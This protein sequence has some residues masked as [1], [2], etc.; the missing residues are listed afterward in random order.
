METAPSTPSKIGPWYSKPPLAAA[1]LSFVIAIV[2]VGCD[3]AAVDNPPAKPE[4]QPMAEKT[5]PAGTVSA[6]LSARTDATLH[7]NDDGSF[8]LVSV[9]RGSTAV[10][11]VGGR[12]AI[13]ASPLV[14]RV[15]LTGTSAVDGTT[16]TLKITGAVRDDEELT[17]TDLTRYTACRITATI[18]SGFH[19]QAIGAMA[20]CLVDAGD[21]PVADQVAVKDNGLSQRLVGKWRFTSLKILPHPGIGKIDYSCEEV[22]FLGESLD[23][24]LE[25]PLLEFSPDT[26]G[27]TQY[28]PLFGLD[29]PDDVA[30]PEFLGVME[31][32]ISFSLGGVKTAIT[33]LTIQGGG[34][35]QSLH[36]DDARECSPIHEYAD[37]VLS[38]TELIDE[39]LPIP[40][41]I[42][43]D[44]Q[45]L[46]IGSGSIGIFLPIL[47]S[48]VE[49]TFEGEALEVRGEVRGYFFYQREP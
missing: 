23:I 16:A 22:R 5:V 35:T 31:L 33:H 30:P 29:D 44:D 45:T 9:T 39:D 8:E 42:S 17:G 38:L 47:P 32:S 13:T 26:L 28:I 41:L 15:V 14:T 34:C 4:T 20:K 6:T 25:C 10:A 1:V 3:S 21:V 46:T 18:G 40:Y 49:S 11:T 36:P 48:A 27:I 37:F 24:E 19:Q 43:D 7:V 12:A 2:M